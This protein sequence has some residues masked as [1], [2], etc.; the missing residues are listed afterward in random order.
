L[1]V[2]RRHVRISTYFFGNVRRLSTIIIN[3]ELDTFLLQ[4]KDVYINVHSAKMSV[5]AWG[6][7]FYGLI[8]I[9][10][11]NGPDPAKFLLFI[12]FVIAGGLL[13]GSVM[14]AADTLTFY[15]GN[16]AVVTRLVTEFLLNFS[17]YPDSI[18]RKEVTW[19]IYTCSWCIFSVKQKSYS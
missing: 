5:S 14:T 10:V 11:I 9:G 13:M 4:P 1:G 2:G 7:L 8:L 15:I 17:L 6:D 19:I 3:G 16:S 12:F 18:F